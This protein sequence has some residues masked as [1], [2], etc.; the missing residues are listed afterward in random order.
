MAIADNLISEVSAIFR[1]DWETTAGRVVPE[2]AS[3]GLGNR[4]IAF[5]SATV[6]YADLDGSTSMV[7]ERSWQFSAEIYKTYLHCA[8][9]IIKAQDGVITAYDG[10]R[11]MAVYV[12][13]RKNSNAALSGLK[14]NWAVS[15]IINPAITSHYSSTGFVLRHVVGIDTSPIR[16]AR[17]GVRGDNDLVW[18][19]RAANYAAK[20]TTLS[21][22]YPTWITGAVYDALAPDAKEYSGRNMWEPRIWKTMRD[23]KIYRSNWSWSP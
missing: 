22:Q 16:V 11:I 8:A 21:S 4:A 17:T 18:V 9:K 14:I 7:D 1:A 13:N 12:G 10:D 3:V 19:G 20:L 15:R 23:M 2:P 5:E 6:L